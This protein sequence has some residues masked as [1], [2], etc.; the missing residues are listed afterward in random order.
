[1]RVRISKRVMAA[2]LVCITLL[3]LLPCNAFAASKTVTSSHSSKI[4]LTVSNT[5][6]EVGETV[7]ITFQNT[8]Y[9]DS[10][11]I[12][13]TYNYWCTMPCKYQ[14]YL[15]GKLYYTVDLKKQY[16]K[17]TRQSYLKLKDK[18][19]SVT[20]KYTEPVEI[21]FVSTYC[22]TVYYSQSGILLESAYGYRS[23]VAT[24]ST[25]TINVA[26]PVHVHSDADRDGFCDKCGYDMRTFSVTVPYAM[27][28]AVSEN[29]NVISA[30]NAQIVNNSNA[31]V[32][33]LDVE[34]HA[35]NG[36]SIVPYST[37]MATEK[38]DSKQIGF[39][40]NGVET[41]ESGTN[42]TLEI[43]AGWQINKAAALQLDY[44]AVVSAVSDSLTNETVLSVVFVVDWTD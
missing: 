28:L 18:A 11:L 14:I 12:P 13:F 37:N 29:G 36:W 4:K 19:Y 21:K 20:F 9:E 39:R 2:V 3:T 25:K 30:A 42:E 7:T 44:D 38:V 34:L 15:N 24:Y 1:M 32:S 27:A 31:P 41:M 23:N 35:E 40:L 22:R 26:A 33:V 43:G 17:N 5:T 16:D 10:S 8:H 6:P